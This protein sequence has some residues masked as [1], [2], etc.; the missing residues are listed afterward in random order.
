MGIGYNPYT[1]SSGLVFCLDPGNTKCYSGLGNTWNDIS[2]YSNNG[3]IVGGVTVDSDG[4][5]SFSLNGTNGYISCGTSN[6][7]SS[8]MTTET[9]IKKKGDNG[10]FMVI[11]N[12]DQPELRL[13]FTST[14]LLIQYYDNGAYFTNTTYNTSIDTN[15][16]Y[17]ITS[18]IQNGSQKYYINGVEILSSSGTYDGS[19][20]TN[21]FEHTLGTYNRPGAGYN[22]Y[23]NVKIAVHK[24]YNRVL[25]A[26]EVTQNFNSLRK[27][28]GI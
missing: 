16:W 25:S 7:S 15:S 27:R 12:F 13:T 24:I 17:N 26:S 11:D 6:I 19:P 2:G 8:T 3:S 10:H 14:G 21:V 1:N 20:T 9:W 18:S 23:A 5:G 22:G 28:F 4:G